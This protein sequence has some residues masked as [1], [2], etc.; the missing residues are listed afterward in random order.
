MDSWEVL[1]KATTICQH[2]AA[3]KVA[4]FLP[5]GA[6][7]DIKYQW[8]CGS[9]TL[10]M[11]KISEQHQGEE[12]GQFPLKSWGDSLIFQFHYV[13]SCEVPPPHGTL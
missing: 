1:L 8:K 11:K 13:L 7:P 4:L 2:K 3:L 10:K 12:K 5:E 9:S 6:I